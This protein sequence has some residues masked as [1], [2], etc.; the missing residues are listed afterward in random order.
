LLFR[1][2]AFDDHLKLQVVGEADDGGDDCGV[3]PVGGDV[4]NEGAV[5]LQGV[6]RETLEV[7]QGGVADP[8]SSTES[9]RPVSHPQL[10]EHGAA[11][12]HVLHEQAPGEPQLQVVRVVAGLVEDAGEAKRARASRKS[13]ALREPRSRAPGSGS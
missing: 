11:H 6:E 1:L 12:R 5:Y 8:K 13:P 9:L 7:A 2:D 4:A 3:V 10:V